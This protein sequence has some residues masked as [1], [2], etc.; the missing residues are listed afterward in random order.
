METSPPV[1]APIYTHG[2]YWGGTVAPYW[3]FLIFTAFP[4]TGFFG[5]DHLLFRSP[6]T[7]LLKCVVNTFTLGLWYMYDIVQSFG[8][9][10][11]VKTYGLSMPAFGP[12]GLAMDYFR[13]VNDTPDSLK[14][15]P[16]GMSGIFF[17]IAYI[18][19][20][21]MPFGIGSLVAGDTEGGIGKLILSCFT[22][23]FIVLFIPYFMFVGI[24]ELYRVVF[25]TQSVLDEGLIRVTPLTFVM[26]SMGTAKYI[27]SPSVLANAAQKDK[28]TGGIYN[29]YIKPL[30]AWIP[31][32]DVLDTTKCAVV[33]PAVK[34]A[35]AAVTAGQGVAEI[36]TTAPAIA[37]KATNKLST[38]TD[39]EKLK[40]AA[41]AAQAGGAMLSLGDPTWDGLIL[42]GIVLMI[43]GGFAVATLRNYAHSI[44]NNPNE[45]PRKKSVN[46]TPP[47]P[48][49]V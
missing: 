18:Y 12:L 44:Q 32:G 3:L 35:Q 39:P 25:Q 20:V 5:I 43:L 21:L 46:E 8:D 17:F 4:L 16:S 28:E 34:T 9:K 14:E 15:S 45:S 26:E 41:V 42:G 49:T 24:Y 22:G 23:L 31:F 30:F 13:N 10:E 47:K 1:K 33:P 19:T 38:F 37:I 11:F 29:K 48:G 40:A 36:A 7:A 27:A 2:K 6:S